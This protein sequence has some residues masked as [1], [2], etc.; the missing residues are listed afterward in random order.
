MFFHQLKKKI[1]FYLIGFLI[2]ETACSNLYFAIYITK[3]FEN[4]LKFQQIVNH[5]NQTFLSFQIP[6]DKSQFSF[7]IIGNGAIAEDSLNDFCKQ[8][9]MCILP[10]VFGGKQTI[11]IY[12]KQKEILNAQIET[13]E[14]RFFCFNGNQWNRRICRFRDIC[15]E[16]NDKNLTFLSPYKITTQSPLLVLGARSPPYDKKRDRIYSIKVEIDR[17][18]TI[19][20]NRVIHNETTQYVST[21][22]N[23]QML[24]HSLFDFSLPLFYTFLAIPDL[25]YKLKRVAI[26]N[27]AD[28]PMNKKF[29]QAFVDSFGRIKRNHCYKDLIVGMEKVKDQETGKLYQFPYNFTYHY[30]PYILEKFEIIKNRSEITKLIPKKPII[31]FS[32]RKTNRRSLSNYDEL[33]ER[34]KNEFSEKFDI[35]KI[36]YEEHD[37]ATQ[38][39]KTYKS[40]IMIGIHGSGL[41]HVCW[42]RPGTVMVEIFP[43]RFDCRDWYERT[44]NVSAVKY[45]KYV[46]KDEEESP[47]ASQAVKDCW[48]KTPKCEGNCLDLLRDQNIKVNVE[49]FIELI[50][51]AADQIL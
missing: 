3:R 29:V 31:L 43:Y 7:K 21:Y 14:N 50:K 18:K 49:K 45:F 47:G 12:Q 25:K 48:N 16:D 22:Y 1:I 32:G 8:E 34:M 27:D 35:E 23:M 11:K 37:M 40:S 5:E 26:P 38:I 39:E 41:S 51:N 13:G 4:P 36:F 33:F 9:K 20:E 42:M 24:F 30:H 17:N 46:P 44:T 6:A 19:P 28:F 15:F 10:L 2:F